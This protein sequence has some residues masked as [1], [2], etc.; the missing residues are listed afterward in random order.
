MAKKLRTRGHKVVLNR[1]RG[2]DAGIT[3]MLVVLGAFMFL[4]ML[5]VVMQSLKPLDELWM[6]PP[7]FFV[8]HPTFSN[9][10]DL[11]SLMSDSWVPFS[12]Y[13]FN[14]VFI[15]AV[16]TNTLAT[17]AMIRAKADACATGENAVIVGCRKADVIIGPV[18]IAIADSLYG[19]VTPAMALAVGQSNAVRIFIPFNHCDNRIVGVADFSLSGLIEQAVAELKDLV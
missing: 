11:F 1:S 3:F 13:I 5:Y 9:F 15:T 8:V 7:R 2:G 19:E 10:T 17:S 12:R 6:F 18:G 16:G 4:P 14:T